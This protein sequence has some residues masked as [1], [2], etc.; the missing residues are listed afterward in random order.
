[1]VAPLI[2]IE[3][4]TFWTE[5]DCVAVLPAP[6]PKPVSVAWAETEVLAGPSA[7]LQSKLPDV[8]VFVA[9]VFVPVPQLVATE[10]IVSPSSSLIE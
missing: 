2:V 7:K 8:F 4:A 10:A 9:F 3:G 5:I 1:M 6:A